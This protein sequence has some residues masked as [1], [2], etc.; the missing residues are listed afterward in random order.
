MA[1]PS[2]SSRGDQV[3]CGRHTSTLFCSSRLSIEVDLLSRGSLATFCYLVPFWG[4]TSP[5][6]RSWTDIFFFRSG[7]A[8]SPRSVGIGR[9]GG[10]RV[11]GTLDLGTSCE[12]V[13]LF[14]QAIRFLRLL[15]PQFNAIASSS[16]SKVLSRRT[17]IRAGKWTLEC[18]SAS[19]SAF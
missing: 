4:L 13:P 8:F 11:R 16:S 15:F 3:H 12:V 9:K 6:S 1:V 7:M 19:S 5:S 2:T 10:G 17:T 14:L 18:L